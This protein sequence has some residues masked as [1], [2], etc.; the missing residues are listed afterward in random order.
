MHP[1]QLKVIS[2][3][4]KKNEG[5]LWPNKTE[6]IYHFL[7][8]QTY[9]GGDVKNKKKKKELRRNHNKMPDH[10]LFVF[11]RFHLPRGAKK[12]IKNIS[13]LNKD[14]GWCWEDGK[15]NGVKRN[16][17]FPVIKSAMMKSEYTF[18]N[19]RE[20]KKLNFFL[21]FT[22]LRIFPRAQTKAFRRFFLELF[23]SLAFFSQLM[24]WFLIVAVILFVGRG[25]LEITKIFFFFF[26]S[27]H[28]YT[29]KR[30]FGLENS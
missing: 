23:T 1:I 25:L 9:R 26:F 13:H 7:P 11:L 28:K 4:E 29:G 17:Q 21:H 3:Q 2:R 20:K 16:S 14:V 15:K 8:P 6:K 12:R 19:M 18:A 22:T 10:N 30:T 5:K 24:N 27:L